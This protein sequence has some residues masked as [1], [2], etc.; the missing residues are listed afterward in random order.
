[1]NLFTSCIIIYLSDML[2]NKLYNQQE[3]EGD[4][5]EVFLQIKANPRRKFLSRCPDLRG[6]NTPPPLLLFFHYDS[7]YDKK[8]YHSLS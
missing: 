2:Q 5:L 7:A 8:Y 6:T 4:V 3:S 1:M